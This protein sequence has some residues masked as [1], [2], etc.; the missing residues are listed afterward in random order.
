MRYYFSAEGHINFYAGYYASQRTGATY[1]SPLNC[2]PGSGWE[3]KEPSLIEIKRSDG[4]N[5]A[6]NRYIVQNGDQR[7]ILIYWYQGRG[8]ST[9][10]EYLDK[11]YT[12]WDSFM[13]RRSD[14]AMVRVMIPVGTDEEKAQNLAVD[15]SSR[16][17]DQISA[18]VPD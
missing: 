8:R 12:S 9:A 5:F 2:M 17:A 11:I 7:Q 3:L 1:H 14:G 18:F 16:V 6:A 10:S 4:R 15:F 13:T